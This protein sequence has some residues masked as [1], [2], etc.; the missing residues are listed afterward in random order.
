MNRT[1]FKKLFESFQ[2]GQIVQW[3]AAA[4]RRAKEAGFDGVEVHG[5]HQYLIASFL[6]SATNIRQDRYGGTVENKARFLVE[7][8]QAIREAVGPDYP[9]WPRLNAQ[10]Y[11]VE[12]GVT[13]EETKQVVPMAVDAGAQAIHVSAYAAGS[14]VTKAPIAD[15]P[16]SFVA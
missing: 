11:G 7:I 12:N 15:T 6:S 1:Q 14:H 4:A 8:L 13:I 3:F 9:I 10:E 5:A 2:I 16:G